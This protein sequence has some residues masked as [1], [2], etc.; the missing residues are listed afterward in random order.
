VGFWDI[1]D[2]AACAANGAAA[3]KARDDAAIR[4][5]FMTISIQ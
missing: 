4:N 5:F 1:A 3:R 2:D